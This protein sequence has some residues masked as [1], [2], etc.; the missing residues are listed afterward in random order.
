[1]QATLNQSLPGI[2]DI[3]RVSRVPD[4]AGGFTESWTT[5]ATVACRL[6]PSG[7]LPHERVIAERLATTSV[8]TLTLP[9]L[10]DVRPADQMVV[11]GRTF[12]VVAVLARSSEIS[13]RVVCTEV[14]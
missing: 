1:M 2:A 12:E 13:R 5:V 8:W 4:G 14:V 3:R 11:G 10:T 9:A 6:S 7:Q